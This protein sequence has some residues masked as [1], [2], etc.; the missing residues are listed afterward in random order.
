MS[1]P[2][3]GPGN[4]DPARVE[5]YLGESAR[6]LAEHG[7]MV[8]SVFGTRPDAGFAYTV[9][10]TG[11]GLPELW[12]G[13]LA[14]EQAAVILNTAAA[15]QLDR[16]VAFQP[17]RLDL[18]FSVEF[19]VHGPVDPD[20]AQVGMARQMHPLSDVAVLQ[21]LWPDESGLFPDEDGYDMSRFP[22]RVLPLAPP[23]PEGT[24]S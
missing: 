15:Q 8:Q 21:L 17:G 19:R 9:G 1:A 6:I 5:A 16:A 18:E 10:L 22:Q 20:A 14:P 7:W 23:A 12:L 3:Y 24:P 4:P 13:T 2:P 11:A